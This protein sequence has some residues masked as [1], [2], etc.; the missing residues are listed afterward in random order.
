MKTDEIEKGLERHIG[1]EHQMYPSNWYLN[2]VIKL[3]A[4]DQLARA[5]DV[6]YKQDHPKDSWINVALTEYKKASK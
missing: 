5:V 6:D 4:A 1:H 3:R 2:I